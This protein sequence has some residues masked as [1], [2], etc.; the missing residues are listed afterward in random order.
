MG[1]EKIKIECLLFTYQN[2]VKI[3]SPFEGGLRG[4]INLKDVKHLKSK[5]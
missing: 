2:F 1:F 5:R 3:T 4:M